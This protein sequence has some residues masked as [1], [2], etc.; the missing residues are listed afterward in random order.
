MTHPTIRDLRDESGIAL[1]VAVVLML[2]VSAIEPGPLSSG[3]ATGVNAMSSMCCAS[4]RSASE[5][6]ASGSGFS[7]AKPMRETMSPPPMRSTGMLMPKNVRI[8]APAS[9]ETNSTPAV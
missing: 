5:T 9:S 7:I 1:L 4:S 3:M 8:T 6:R 2:M